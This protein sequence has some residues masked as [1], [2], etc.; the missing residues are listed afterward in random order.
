MTKLRFL[1]SAKNE[2]AATPG[3]LHLQ[4]TAPQQDAFG[5]N[6]P[7]VQFNIAVTKAVADEY[8]VGTLYDFDPA[9]V[10]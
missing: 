10:A 2:L 4:F 9:A 7:N 6:A 8:A 1:C 5:P 3:I